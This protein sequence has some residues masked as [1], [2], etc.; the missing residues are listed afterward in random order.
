[1]SKI[2]ILSNL[3]SWIKTGI[4]L[5]TGTNIEFRG[6]AFPIGGDATIDG[7]VIFKKLNKVIKV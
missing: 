5:W 4:G 3:N 6:A 7:L 1:M 2:F